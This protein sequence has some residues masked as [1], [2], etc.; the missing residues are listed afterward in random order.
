[1]SLARL[2]F[3]DFWCLFGACLVL[4]FGEKVSEGD[5]GADHLGT[6]LIPLCCL[7]A[8]FRNRPGSLSNGPKKQKS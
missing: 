4:A 6:A 1:M 3:A 8:L 2:P 7:S 5:H